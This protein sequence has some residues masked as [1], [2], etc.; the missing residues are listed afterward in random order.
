[1]V[2]LMFDTELTKR[3]ADV[4]ASFSSENPLPEVRSFITCDYIFF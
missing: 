2:G 1:M 4:L 3:L